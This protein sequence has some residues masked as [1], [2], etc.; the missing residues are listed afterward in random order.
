M[1]YDQ[2]IATNHIG[3]LGANE[4]KILKWKFEMGQEDREDGKGKGRG[5]GKSRVPSIGQSVMRYKGADIWQD[6][7]GSYRVSV[8]PES[9][10]DGLREAKAFVGK[11]AV[12]NPKGKG[13]R[14]SSLSHRIGKGAAQTAQMYTQMFTP[15]TYARLAGE[16]VGGV[17]DKVK[18]MVSGKGKGKSNPSF[19]LATQTIPATIVHHKHAH[20]DVYSIEPIPGPLGWIFVHGGYESERDAEAAVMEAVEVAL[21]N[22][23]GNFKVEIKRVVS[24]SG[25]GNGSRNGNGNGHGGGK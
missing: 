7:D 23:K 18:G 13:K 10:F 4:A 20:Y 15:S 8:D 11:W 12:A 19:S 17:L 24:G 6:T 25:N 21:A 5:K 14:V 3:D 16:T 1:T 22:V 9:E 2:W